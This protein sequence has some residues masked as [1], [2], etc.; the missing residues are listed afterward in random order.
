MNYRSSVVQTKGEYFVFVA[1]Y[2]LF[3]PGTSVPNLY[4]SFQLKI[5]VSKFSIQVH[6]PTFIEVN[7]FIELW[8]VITQ[9]YS[10]CAI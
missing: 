4:A 1:F 9:A 5:D 8:Q 3:W 7:L 2:L 6:P 10:K